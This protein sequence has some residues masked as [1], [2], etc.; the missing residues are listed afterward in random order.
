MKRI[1]E[2]HHR[3]T[4]RDLLLGYI[5]HCEIAPNLTG[6]LERTLYHAGSKYAVPAFSFRGPIPPDGPTRFIGLVAGR[7]GGDRLSAEVTLQL[8]ERLVLQP[9]LGEG[10]WLRILPVLDPV[11]LERGGDVSPPGGIEEIDEAVRR[12][13]GHGVIEIAASD[14]A[15]PAIGLRAGPEWKE[16]AF[17]AIESTDRLASEGDGSPDP[18]Y[19]FQ[20]SELPR[21]ARVP[22][23]LYIAIPDS[24]NP[25][26]ATHFASQWLLVFFRH[27]QSQA[28]L[29]PQPAYRKEFVTV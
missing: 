24:W 29:H 2:R 16:A 10:L 22:W 12:R 28:N 13:C 25:S 7:H 11:G 17:T 18:S 3:E 21:S 27:L 26:E 9:N 15:F 6:T 23:N 5:E 19:R 4:L 20:I 1:L 8:I 14:R